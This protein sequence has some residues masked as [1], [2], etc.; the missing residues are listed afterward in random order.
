MSQPSPRSHALPAWIPVLM[1]MV[2]WAAQA[3]VLGGGF[4]LDDLPV[5]R[6][7][8]ALSG[9]AGALP[10][11]LREPSWPGELELQPYRPLALT[12]LALDLSL[13]GGPFGAHAAQGV[14][15]LSLLLHGVCAVL[16]LLLLQG[17]L[18]GRRA[19]AIATTLAF[20]LHPLA[21]G[22]LGLAVGRADV[23]GL[24]LGLAALLAW[25]AI[26]TGGAVWVPVC[27]LALLGAL[28][29][30]EALV[31]LPLVFWLVERVEPAPTG[32]PAPR[33]RL[34]GWLAVAGV[35]AVYLLLWPGPG[36][37]PHA[38]AA[39]GQGTT[40][41]LGLE[42]L[43]RAAW[44]ALLPVGL[45]ADRS[46][47]AVAGQGFPTSGLALFAALLTTFLLLSALLLPARGSRSGVL[48]AAAL[49]GGALALPS[50][51]TLPP[52]A[53]LED[54]A[55]YVLLPALA[56]PLGLL[57]EALLAS[58][59][60]A[61]RVAGRAGAALAL[62]VF[63]VLGLREAGAGRDDASLGQALM[64]REAGHAPAMLRLARRLTQE[65]ER[66]RL[67]AAQLSVRDPRQAQLAA[68][69]R[70]VAA[71]ALEH[72]ERAVRVPSL[73]ADPEAWLALGLARLEA[74]EPV[75]AA[76]AL[77]QARTLE[78]LLMRGGESGPAGE[79]PRAWQRA[80]RLYA[81]LARVHALQGA[82]S[83]AANDHE[84]AVRFEREAARRLGR[85]VNFDLLHRAAMAL[86]AD[87][88]Y[89]Q[90]LSLAEETALGAPDP[91]LR[92]QAM[93]FLSR[94]RRDALERLTA[95]LAEGAG[96]YAQGQMGP[97]VGAYEDALRVAPASVEARAW[98]AR[99]RGQYFGNFALARRYVE[100]GLELLK[101]QPPGDGVARDRARLE[102]LR[103]DLAAW[104]QQ[105]IR[106]EQSDDAPRRR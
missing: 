103:S 62:A 100:E 6:D 54:R 83:L 12:S 25:R 14:R 97:A 27:A 28:L 51:F 105:D 10:R 11:V 34:A 31:G 96:Y 30:K 77:A 98:A 69:S 101:A 33:A 2:A 68:S 84:E 32:A 106:E 47:E 80:A 56:L 41:L 55:A 21:P 90:A 49:A 13:W 17:L 50:V 39:P 86:G 88:R 1:L 45:L 24:C 5:V 75:A 53:L 38:G 37:A 94:A 78:P 89:G 76:D 23:L 40:L 42:G 92:R 58:G 102:Q 66:Q 81:A 59:Q 48:R 64:E 72:N 65:A 22:V 70:A 18:P 20:A 85:A 46:V 36:R 3:G 61:G 15:L 26:R 99:L 71:Q 29:C 63:V 67:E 95:L 35:L 82:G 60:G 57:L 16:L 52:G 87:G 19:L 43:G 104:E 93:E 79:D 91:A 4:V 8:P 7:N 74:D 9:G 73:R 44:K